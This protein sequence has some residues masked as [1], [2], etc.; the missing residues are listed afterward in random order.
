VQPT[1]WAARPR[2][3]PWA[4][5]T[6]AVLLALGAVG[7]WWGSQ[8]PAIE[9][10]KAASRGA[11]DP[12]AARAQVRTSIAVLP[13]V[14][15]SGGAAQDYFSDGVTEDLIAA[16]G[17]FPELA[18]VAR[19]ASF[20]Y[21]GKAT[22][23]KDIGREPGVRYIIEGSVSRAGL[24]VRVSAQ[25]FDATVRTLLWSKQYDEEF[26]ERTVEYARKAL[27]LDPDNP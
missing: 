11:S 10:P 17:R 25:L 7:L 20:S 16:L 2:V 4:L 12:G 21:K 22:G 27:A 6:L 14:N 8:S 23:P 9:S 15:Q 26:K 19:N 13:F 3:P 1:L 18:V 24:R 5:A